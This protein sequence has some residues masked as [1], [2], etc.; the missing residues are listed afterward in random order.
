MSITIQAERIG[1]LL[2]DLLGRKVT[3]TTAASPISGVEPTLTAVYE[4]N[5]GNV[6]AACCCDLDLVLNAGAALVLVPARDVQESAK[7]K[8]WDPLL[9]ENFKEILNVC[10]QLFCQAGSPRAKLGC[11]CLTCSQ[12]NAKSTVAANPLAK[13]GKRVDVQLSIAGYASGRMAVFTGL[14]GRALQCSACPTRVVQPNTT[15]RTAAL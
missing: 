15:D 14:S 9:V 6:V 7:A 12:A 13:G 8:K 3:A 1:R 5:E 11:L 2:G 10:A 4:D